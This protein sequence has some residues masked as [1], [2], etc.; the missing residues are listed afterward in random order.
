M[1]DFNASEASIEETDLQGHLERQR[2]I[3]QSMGTNDYII[4]QN[5]VIL[6]TGANGFIGPRVI[7]SLL[8]LGFRNIRCLA[9]PTSNP[10]KM[11]ALSSIQPNGAHVAV[12]S[13]NLLSREDCV[14]AT[15]DA[16]VV[17]HLAAAR[18]E[19]SYPD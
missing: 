11:G 6:V 8:N 12:F 7:Q 17:V 10:A 2:N 3:E 15:R 9:R 14:A 4:G 16:A 5:D 19:K 18:G 1:H 13:G